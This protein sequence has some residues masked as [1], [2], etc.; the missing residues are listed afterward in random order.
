MI[1]DLDKKEHIPLIRRYPKCRGIQLANE[2]LPHLN[3]LKKMYVID[4]LEDWEKV[5]NEFPTEM[6]TVRC[7]CSRGVEA[8]L[9]GGQTF[10][11]N[12]VEAYIT[13]VKTIVPNA[14]I[15]LE[16]MKPGTNERIH[17]SGAVCLDIRIGDCIYMDYVGPSFDCGDITK[18]KSAHASWVIPWNDA[19]FLK[20][21]TIRKYLVSEIPQDAYEEV[22]EKRTETLISWYPEQQ[23]EIKTTVPKIAPRMPSWLFG[24]IAEKVIFPLYLQHEKLSRDGF[25]NFGLELNITQSTLLLY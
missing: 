9:P 20:S 16:D 8:K 12:Q 15:M 2:Y 14:V 21:S 11:R 13:K 7:D 3:P 1:L 17:S 23:E 18:G 24:D 5:K 10:S 19:P 25:R 22:A 4:S 6:M